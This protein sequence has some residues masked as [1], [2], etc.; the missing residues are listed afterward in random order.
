MTIVPAARFEDAVTPR[1]R[2]EIRRRVA[3][4]VAAC[5]VQSS[6]REDIARTL[7]VVLEVASEHAPPG[8]DARIAVIADVM[9]SDV[10]VVLRL[11]LD[12]EPC[13]EGQRM[14]GFELWMSF[15]RE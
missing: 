8:D 2:E 13:D 9:P 3:D 15:P 4:F 5:G 1:G 10:Q 12:G 11:C 14:G 7:V 6:D